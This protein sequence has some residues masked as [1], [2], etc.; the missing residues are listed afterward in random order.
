[1]VGVDVPENVLQ[2]GVVIGWRDA[3]SQW[4]ET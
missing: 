3:L 4:P 2:A 1:V